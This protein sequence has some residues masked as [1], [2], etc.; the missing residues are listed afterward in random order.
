M[1]LRITFD[2]VQLFEGREHD[3]HW[4]RKHDRKN[5]RRQHKFS[6]NSYVL[7]QDFASIFSLE[8]TKNEDQSTASK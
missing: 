5:C 7:K 4:Y 8:V 3:K 2:F 1:S 6:S